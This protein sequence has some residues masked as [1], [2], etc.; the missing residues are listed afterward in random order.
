MQTRR[1]RLGTAGMV[2]FPLTALLLT[3]PLL[4]GC[5]VEQVQLGEWYTLYTPPM[6]AC[7]QLAWH[8]VA[9]AQRQIGGYLTRDWQRI[10]NLNGTLAA[11]DSFRITAT[12]VAGPRTAEVTGQ[13]TSDVSTIAIHGSAAGPACDGQVFKMRLRGFFWSQGGGGGGGG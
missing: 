1:G 2:A 8:F 5:T 3:G 12:E 7:P 10:A 13:F 9:D 4:S 6:G 11:D